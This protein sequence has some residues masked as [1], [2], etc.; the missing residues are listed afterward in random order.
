MRCIKRHTRGGIIVGDFDTIIKESEGMKDGSL[1]TGG[2]RR[3]M[4][5][6]RDDLGCVPVECVCRLYTGSTI[7]L[8]KLSDMM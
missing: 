3:T 6:V 1:Q 8:P 4:D 7:D 5:V 2:G